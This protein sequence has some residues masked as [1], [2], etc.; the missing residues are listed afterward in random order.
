MGSFLALNK[1]LICYPCHRGREPSDLRV[2]MTLN[3][4][5]VSYEPEGLGIMDLPYVEAITGFQCD[6]SRGEGPKNVCT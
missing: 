5:V 2:L 4:A 6:P 3:Y 1:I